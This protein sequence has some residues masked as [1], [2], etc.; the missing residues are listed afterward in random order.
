MSIYEIFDRYLNRPT[1]FS[2]H[3]LE[4][5]AFH[6]ALSHVVNDPKFNPEDMGSYFRRKTGAVERDGG[7]L[8]QAIDDRVR[9]AWAVRDYLQYKIPDTD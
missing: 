9:D 7:E 5:E 6:R 8:D 2:G 3:D 1:W 4:D